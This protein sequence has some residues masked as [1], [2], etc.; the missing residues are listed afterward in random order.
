MAMRRELQALKLQGRGK[1]M[2]ITAA[3]KIAINVE[4]VDY[5]NVCVCVHFG[6]KILQRAAIAQGHLGVVFL[7]FF[8]LFSL[9]IFF[10]EKH[11]W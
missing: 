8:F 4:W 7:S 9:G 1:F 5:V 10:Y 2:M 6:K 3:L 11:E